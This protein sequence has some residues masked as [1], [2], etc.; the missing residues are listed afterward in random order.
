MSKRFQHVD[1]IEFEGVSYQSFPETDTPWRVRGVIET[2]LSKR[3]FSICMS[4]EQAEDVV[5][6][7]QSL[8]GLGEK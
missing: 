4:R 6:Q 5:T 2:D 1:F 8:L 3:L 7:L